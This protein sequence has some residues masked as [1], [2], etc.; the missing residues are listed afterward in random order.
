[1]PDSRP[2]AQEDLDLGQARRRAKELLVAVR[3][4]DSAASVRLV[5]PHNPVRFS[6]AQHGVALDLGFASWLHL[7]RATERFEPT[8]LTEVDWPRVRKVT[9]VCFQRED[10]ALFRHGG[11]LLMPHG[12]RSPDEDV[13][14]DTVRR[15]PMEGMRFRHESTHLFAIDAARRHTVFWVDGALDDRN[16]HAESAVAAETLNVDA[17][18]KTLHSQGDGALARLVAA[19]AE[20]RRHLTYEQHQRDSDRTTTGVYLRAS[21][22]QGGSGYSG[23]EDE[24]RSARAGL[25][26]ALTGLDSD[27]GR[28]GEPVSFLDVGCANGHLAASFVTWGA[29]LGVIVDP[30]G[31]DISPALTR[32]AKDLH[33]RR[34]DHFRTGNMLTWRHPTGRR[35]DLGH[36]LLDRLPVDKHG[37]AIANCHRFLTAGGR[38]RISMYDFRPE[39][40]AEAVASQLE[41][42]IVDRTPPRVRPGGPP[43]QP[44]VWVSLNG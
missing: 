18:T 12:P 7:V 42:S 28:P 33:P 9:V 10:L 43:G 16:V 17:A 38:L 15:L 5:R 41:Y 21:T 22:P 34:I 29:E 19:A 39:L 14:D 4:G 23:D 25:A 2:Q 37:G 6:D 44:S 26:A 40:A 31:V 24:W 3:R 1:M 20:H 36:V 11:R 27:L 32:R 35:F 30:Y 8:D 13:W